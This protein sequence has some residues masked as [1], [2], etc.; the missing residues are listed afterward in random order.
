LVD[1]YLGGTSPNLWTWN[2][3]THLYSQ[4]CGR[5][6]WEDYGL[7]PAPPK[8]LMRSY[9]KKQTGCGGTLLYTAMPLA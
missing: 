2:A 6:R 3:E 7:R 8:E 5:H 1:S 9:L 4:L